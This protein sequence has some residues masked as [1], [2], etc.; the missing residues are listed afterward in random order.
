M[1]AQASDAIAL[2]GGV[3]AAS[4]WQGSSRKYVDSARKIKSDKGAPST[5]RSLFHFCPTAMP[6][7]GKVLLTAIS[8]NQESANC[9]AVRSGK[10][11][12]IPLMSPMWP[13]ES[14][15]NSSERPSSLAYCAEG[16]GCAGSKASL[17]ASA[18]DF[19]Y[20]ARKRGTDGLLPPD[21]SRT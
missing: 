13:R 3:A 9:D 14:T 21:A 7:A 18:F 11:S 6:G 5:G 20:I 8:L 12:S 17:C 15:V 2:A 1:T 16:D 10:M 19:S 4:G